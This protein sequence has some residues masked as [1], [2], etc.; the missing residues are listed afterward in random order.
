VSGDN[1][2]DPDAYRSLAELVNLLMDPPKNQIKPKN[3]QG[4]V[5]H[6]RVQVRLDWVKRAVSEKHFIF[7]PAKGRSVLRNDSKIKTHG[8][9]Y[10]LPKRYYDFLCG[11]ELDSSSFMG[12]RDFVW[13]TREEFVKVCVPLSFRFELLLTRCSGLCEER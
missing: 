13:M 8:K 6:D 9:L 3:G 10:G 5:M 7:D 4:N 12:S 2:T 1:I 11:N